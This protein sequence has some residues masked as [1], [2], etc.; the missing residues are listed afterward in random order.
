MC[1]IR[2]Y[3]HQI[4]ATREVVTQCHTYVRMYVF[5][6]WFCTHYLSN[7]RIYTWR[8][9]SWTPSHIHLGLGAAWGIPIPRASQ[10]S[11]AGDSSECLSLLRQSLH[12]LHVLPLIPLHQDYF[13][14]VK[15]PMDLG[16]IDRKLVNGEYKNPWEVGDVCTYMWWEVGDVCTYVHVVGGRGCVYLRTCGGR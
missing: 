3:V 1:V 6:M 16:T 12:V 5:S 9:G 15:H 10:P 13:N 4:H 7:G 2:T 8:V 14:I 11:E